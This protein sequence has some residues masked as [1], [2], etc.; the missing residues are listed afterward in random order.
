MIPLCAYGPPTRL[1]NQFKHFVRKFESIVSMHFHE[2][3]DRRKQVNVY[4][5]NGRSR[6]TP[7]RLARFEL[8]HHWFH[9]SQALF[10]CEAV[11]V[12]RVHK[13]LEKTKLQPMRECILYVIPPHSF[14]G[15]FNGE[16]DIHVFRDKIRERFFVHQVEML[17]QLSLPG[18]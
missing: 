18:K 15:L 8:I 11:Y 1:E 7:S 9:S 4:H 3:V 16:G 5:F 2:G 14:Y 6:T 12:R 13:L 17:D 10:F